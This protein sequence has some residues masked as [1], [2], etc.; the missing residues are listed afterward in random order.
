MEEKTVKKSKKLILKK[1]KVSFN[2]PGVG[3]ILESSI[4]YPEQIYVREFVSSQSPAFQC[5][6]KQRNKET[7]K[8]TH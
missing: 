1:K 3:A 7:K 8:R 2:T 6:V 5:G 4:V